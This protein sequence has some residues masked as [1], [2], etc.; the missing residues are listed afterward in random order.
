[1]MLSKQIATE[2]GKDNIRSNCISPG[3][4]ET[5]L[6]AGFYTV[7]GIREK[8]ESVTPAGRIGQPR[9]ISDAALFLASD[10]ASFITGEEVTVDGGY[11]KM[12]MNLIPRPG[13]D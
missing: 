10:R 12:L 13:F 5:P 4:I 8:R 6:T 2:W 1:L 11:T 7:E 9:D 3:M